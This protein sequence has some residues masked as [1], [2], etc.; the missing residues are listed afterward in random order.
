MKTCVICGTELTGK[1]ERFCSPSCQNAWTVASPAYAAAQKRR[2]ERRAA[3]R[4]PC[5]H[6]GKPVHRA[7]LVEPL[8]KGCRDAWRRR[9]TRRRDAELKMSTAAVGT[10]GGVWIAGPC[11]RC[12]QEFVGRWHPSAVGYCSPTCK[13]AD[14]KERV[15]RHKVY[16]RDG[17]RCQLCGKPVKR[18]AAVPH[19]LAPVLDHVIP[20]AVGGT[21][22]PANVQC[23]HFLCNS[24]KGDR[25]GGEQL[26]L[27]G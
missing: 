19:P 12:G 22:E 4:P 18:D 3:A 24:V 16:V 2:A 9:M 21:H 11:R 20:L 8:H 15:W 23:A 26:L 25:G 7:L 1:R 17:W 14:A 27:I 13:A 5:V 6:C 10:R